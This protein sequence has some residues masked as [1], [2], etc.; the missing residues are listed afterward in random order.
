MLV[1]VLIALGLLWALLD[2]SPIDLAE[3]GGGLIAD[4]AEQGRQLTHATVDAS[5]VVTDDPRGLVDAAGALLGR[6]VDPDAYALARMLRSEEGTAGQITK[7]YLANVAQN[8]A[9]ALG[10][11]IWELMLYHKTESRA[12]RFGRQISGRFA[13][14]S[15]PFESDLAA[16]E[17]ALSNP[18]QTGGALNFADRRAFGVQEGST[19][20]TDF[21]AS[22]A[23]EGKQP[24]TLPSAPDKLVFFWRGDLPDN[25]TGVA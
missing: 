10:W 6:P 12:G 11:S 17:W 9:R 18:D 20:F 15:D 13:T 19:T 14:T 5:G 22:L 23:K 24:G 25:A 7:V 2:V 16:A 1:A 8:Q 4:L 21:A 3:L